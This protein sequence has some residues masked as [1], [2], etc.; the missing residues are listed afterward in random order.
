ML[1]RVHGFN[2][3]AYTDY[4]MP[5]FTRWLVY[6]DAK[7]ICQ[8]YEQ[9]RCAHEE[10]FMPALMHHLRSWPRAQAFV[11]QLPQG[12]YT[13]REYKLLCD[14]RSFTAV[15]DIYVHR[16]P[17][18]L[19]RD[20][21]ALRVIWGALVE[22]H[23]LPWFNL[24]NTGDLSATLAGKEAVL[25]A[26]GVVLGHHPAIIHMRGW[27]SSFS[28][29]AMALF[30]FLACGRRCMPFGYRA[31]EPYED[32]VGYLTPIEVLHLAE[33]LRDADAPETPQAEQ[34]YAHFRMVHDGYTTNFRLLDEILPAHAGPFL[35]LV[36][37]AAQYGVG[38]I[39]RIE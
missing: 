30:E 22:R 11:Q 14:P 16:H 31:G 17:P 9:T 10:Q 20:S 6:D 37:L 35:E 33:C 1:A 23:C 29:R 7:M 36:R 5:A 34:D 19:Y 13:Q 12:P 38:L 25:E 3:D 24:P 21:N 8:L 27:L 4:I 2:W 32:T 15:S 28:I 26:D 18:R 39:C